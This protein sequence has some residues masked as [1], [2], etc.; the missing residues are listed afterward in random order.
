MDGRSLHPLLGGPGTWPR[1]RGVLAE[2]DSRRLPKSDDSEC[3]CAYH[4]IRTRH[5]LYS[6]PF[7]G[8]S[9][10]YD[11]RRDPAELRNRIHSRKYAKS[12]R[13]LAARLDLLRRCSGVEGRD[14]PATAPFCE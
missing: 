11:L 13:D 7:H 2:I 10:L 1:G 14:P 5:Y 4:A 8:E 12:R 6:E 3:Q 9:E